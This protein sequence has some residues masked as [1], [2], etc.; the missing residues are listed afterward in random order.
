M[1]LE[2][3]EP[4]LTKHIEQLNSKGISKGEEKFLLVNNLQR[5][6]LARDIIY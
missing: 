1:S 4:L 5:M 6:A 3:F 2:K